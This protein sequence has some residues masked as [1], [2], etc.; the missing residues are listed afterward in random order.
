MTASTLAPFRIAITGAAGRMGRMLVAAVLAHPA[1]VL[2]A[3]TVRPGD[4]AAGQ[5]AGLLAGVGACGV[6][7]G[8]DPAQALLAADACI[9]FTGPAALEEHARLA[10]Q[11]GT[12]LV[13]GSTGLQAAQQH[14]LALAARHVPVVRAA[15]FSL[16]VALLAALTR[17]AAAALDADWDIEILE[18]HHR[19]KQDAP[20]GTALELGRAAA[21][22]RGLDEAPAQ[23]DRSG[24]R[25]RGDIGYAVLRG[26]DV[27]GDHMVVFATEGERL[28][29]AHRA[30]SRRIFASGA[31]RAALW[32][33][34]RTP[35]LY[36]I[37][38]VL[39]LAG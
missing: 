14:F 25:P 18:M 30:G 35:G 6:I 21:A 10:A 1:C 11:A 22:G 9:D 5:D 17:R 12:A 39:A 31:V 4:S 33:R 32:C 15:N 24:P 29:L 3:A 8:E 37:D 16:G 36:G 38:D 19:H 28:E 27:S 7:L 34:G 20:S 2:H 13:V 23:T 26:G